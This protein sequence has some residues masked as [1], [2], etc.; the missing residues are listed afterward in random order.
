MPRLV[1]WLKRF[2]PRYG[3]SL[4]LEE[5]RERLQGK[6]GKCTLC[7]DYVISLISD[8]IKS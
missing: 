8:T 6:A 4:L 5:K 7:V 2:S 1:Q 3:P